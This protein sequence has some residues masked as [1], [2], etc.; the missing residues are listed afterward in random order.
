MKTTRNDSV[1]LCEHDAL[2]LSQDELTSLTQKTGT[3]LYL[4]DEKGLRSSVESLF[5]VFSALQNMRGYF[6]LHL[7]AQREILEVLATTKIGAYCLTPEE[8]RLAL[9]CGF[10]GERLVYAPM[11]LDAEMA[12]ILCDLNIELMVVNP[13]SLEHTLPKRVTLACSPVRKVRNNLTALGYHRAPLGLI[14]SEVMEAVPRLAAAG[15][16]LGLAII[17][18][19]NMS[20]ETH[21]ANKLKSL[22]KY[23]KELLETT[24]VDIRRL[25]PGEGP[26]IRYNRLM[27][28]MDME[29]LARNAV[30]ALE[31]ENFE[32]CMNVGKRILEPNG[33]FVTAVQNIIPRE[34]PTMVV[35]A[36]SSQ[37]IP[38]QMDRY[39]HVSI[40]G[41]NWVKG[42]T[43]CDV[44]G[45]RALSTDWIAERIILPRPEVGDLVVLYD[46][47][48]GPVKGS[49]VPCLLL[50]EDGTVTRLEHCEE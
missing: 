2:F 16:D 41:K 10:D 14:R 49:G 39:R 13:Q 43:M 32:I 15:H 35:D 30:A 11:L 36:M 23:Q 6:P 26:G 42:R 5:G 20:E 28:P 40:V 31:D 24:G 3:P 18:G 1:E 46:A 37:I 17:E 8:L 4:Y 25:H 12:Q 47:G 44:I 7:F 45:C 34:R 50:R 38:S 33:I 19:M 27:P 9:D 48:S 29:L 21:L 22:R